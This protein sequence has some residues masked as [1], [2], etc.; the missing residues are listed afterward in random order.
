MAMGSK[1]NKIK[2]RI[3]EVVGALTDHDNR[4]CE[5]QRD[6]VVGKVQKAAESDTEEVQDP[7]GT[8]CRDTLSRPWGLKVC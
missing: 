1:T 5:R 6:Q 3:E 4:K 8:P 2:G 7:G